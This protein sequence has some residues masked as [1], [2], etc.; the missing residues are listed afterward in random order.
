M[1]I[2]IKETPMKGNIIKLPLAAVF[3]A[4]YAILTLIYASVV[5]FDIVTSVVYVS[6]YAAMGALTVMYKKPSGALAIPITV[7]GILAI[8]PG[9]LSVFLLIIEI[10]AA[11]AVFTYYS[12]LAYLLI[13]CLMLYSASHIL[14]AIFVIIA[15]KKPQSKKIKKLWFLP[16]V[17]LSPALICLAVI[18]IPFICGRPFLGIDYEMIFIKYGGA[19]LCTV[20]LLA[21]FFMSRWISKS[22]S[23]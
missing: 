22:D 12:F 17:L 19:V 10:R 14:S 7:L 3:S 11:T 16:G 8:V 23:E 15:V 21:V 4:F 2:T 9:V 13:L 18:F 20:K 1:N 5:G 6:L